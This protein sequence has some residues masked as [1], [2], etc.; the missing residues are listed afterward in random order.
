MSD[1]GDEDGGDEEVEGKEDEIE[2]KPLGEVVDEGGCED[3]AEGEEDEEEEGVVCSWII[4]LRIC[5]GRSDMVL[6]RFG[7]D[8]GGC[9][10][11]LRI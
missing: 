10:V 9:C 6:G 4:V 7:W 8:H 3:C 5:E 2:V 11:R 1:E